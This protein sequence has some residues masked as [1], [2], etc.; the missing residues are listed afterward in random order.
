VSVWPEVALGELCHIARGGS[1]RPIKSFLTTDPD[2]INWIKIGDASAG[3]GKFISS[4]EERI[5]REGLKMSRLVEPGDFLLSNSMS[6]GRPYIMRTTGCIHDGW[7]VLKDKS[8]RFD[9]DYLY[10]FLGSEAAYRQFDALA[11]GSTVRNLN[12]EL[13]K[14]VKVVLPPLEEQRRVVAVLDK[15]FAAIATATANAEKYLASAREMYS[16]LVEG[17]FES[18]VNWPSVEISKF[19]IVYDG[20]HATP[21]TVDEGP[22]FLGISALEDGE[23]KL[24]K[25]RHVTPA[26]FVTWTKRVKPKPNDVVFSYE[27]R[28][29]QAAIIPEGLECCLGRRMGLLRV[30]EGAKVDPWFLLRSYLSPSFQRFLRKN[31]VQGATVDRFSIKDFPSFS[32][33]VPT[34][35][36]QREVVQAC[37]QAK[38]ETNRLMSMASEKLSLLASLRRSLLHRAFS[39]QLTEREPLAA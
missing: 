21:K 5:R 23:I 20:P 35:E 22:I 19:A 13:V 30:R 38:L 29:G 27:T 17:I 36:T 14:T 34:L 39:G 2:G 7:L 1:P 25:T 15:A 6:F 12:T 10:Y 4:T 26:D 32:M 9:P 37:Q 11:A 3:D 18:E 31:I 16:S 28:L 8:H 24:G 33:R